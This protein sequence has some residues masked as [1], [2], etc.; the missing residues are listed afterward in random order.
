MNLNYILRSIFALIVIIWLANV[1]LRK[2]NSYMQG[3]SKAIQIIERFSI[4]KNSSLTIVKILNNYYLMSFNENSSEILKEFTTEEIDEITQI[5]QN[6][7]DYN[8]VEFFAQIDFSKLKG[9]YTDF[10]EKNQQ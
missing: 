3:Q 2:L 5:M 6:Q 8:P 4:S 7:E 1:L 9:K 10:F